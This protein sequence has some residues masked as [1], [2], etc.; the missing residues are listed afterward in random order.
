MNDS[1]GRVS[2]FFRDME[3]G[4][5]VYPDIRGNKQFFQ[6]IPEALKTAKLESHLSQKPGFYHELTLSEKIDRSLGVFDVEKQKTSVCDDRSKG[7]MTK[8]NDRARHAHSLGE[9][10]WCTTLAMSG[11]EAMSLQNRV[12]ALGPSSMP[13]SML[14]SSTWAPISTCPLA[15]VSAA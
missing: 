1:V 2:I 10:T 9:Q 15:T 3:S 7:Q 6:P 4:F 5:S 8:R 11:S 12:I 13:S 14:M